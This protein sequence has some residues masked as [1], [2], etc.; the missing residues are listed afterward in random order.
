M[1]KGTAG[2]MLFISGRSDAHVQDQGALAQN[3]SPPRRASRSQGK[4]LPVDHWKRARHS[5]WLSISFVI[6]YTL[7]I[8]LLV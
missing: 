1:L 4:F 7:F 2:G 3:G 6:F 8:N 5:T